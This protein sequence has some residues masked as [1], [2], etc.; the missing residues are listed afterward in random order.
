MEHTQPAPK[1]GKRMWR[2]AMPP[3]AGAPTPLRLVTRAHASH[4][5]G[6]RRVSTG[7]AGLHRVV[8][9]PL[10]AHYTGTA[11][12]WQ[13]PTDGALAL[14]DEPAALVLPRPQ[15]GVRQIL[16]AEDDRSLAR[17]VRSVLEEE[18]G[19]AWEV[20]VAR[21]GQRALDLAATT[22]PDL[23]LLDVRL[24][25]LNGVEVYRRL[26][27]EAD[28]RSLRVIFISAATSYDLQ[29]MGIEDGVLLR[30]PFDM[31]DL[32]GIVRAILSCDA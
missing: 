10:R 14:A 18:G 16:L 19:S 1:P 12:P 11:A 23:L 22:P 6:V 24:P 3:L 28:G 5:H 8:E 17:V 25:G 27:E 13:S 2:D 32:T 7:D 26:R 31:A 4:V 20:R 15:T 29:Q 30:K 21:T 9:L